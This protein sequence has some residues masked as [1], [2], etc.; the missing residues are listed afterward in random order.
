MKVCPHFNFDLHP[1]QSPTEYRVCGFNDVCHVL[2]AFWNCICQLQTTKADDLSAIVLLM[3]AVT[4]MKTTIGSDNGLYVTG[5]EQRHARFAAVAELLSRSL[6]L[7]RGD[8]VFELL[9]FHPTYTRDN[10]HP[11]D[12][13]AHGHLPQTSWL[14]QILKHYLASQDDNDTDEGKISDADLQRFN[15]QRRAPVT[16][17]CIKRVASLEELA[18]RQNLDGMT[19]DLDVGDGVTISAST[20][21]SY[22]R[23]ILRM[24]K[25]DEATLQA[26]LE[27]ELAVAAEST[28]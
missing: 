16:A 17:V 28:S 11:A 22:A 23:N 6:C 25:T 24:A 19:T 8:N 20:V 26:E 2:S 14:R 27:E 18:T 4:D 3:P 13:P 15:Y 1:Q 10:I 21:A 9:H 12:R 7:Y 5:P